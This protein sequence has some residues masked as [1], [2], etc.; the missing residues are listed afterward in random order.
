MDNLRTL[1]QADVADVEA[2]RSQ[3]TGSVVTPAD[4]DW[5]EARQA[6]NLAVDQ[7]P[8]LVAL[9][10]T[11]QDVAAVVGY[12]AENRLQVAPQGTGHNA[13]AL[14]SLDDTILLKTS[15]MRGV[16]IDAQARTARAEA[17]VIWIEVVEAAARHGLASLAGSSPDVG[18][19][20][21]TLG[22]GLSWLGRK[23]G[24]AANNVVA[25]EL[26]TADGRLVRATRDEEPDLFWAVRGGGGAFGVVTAIEF[27]LFPI[28]EVYAGVLWF[29]FERAADV[30]HAWRDFVAAGTPDELTTVGRLLQLPP[31][32]VIPE[33]VRGKSFVILEA[34]YL[35]DEAEGARLLEPL[36]ALGPVLDTVATIPVEALAHLHMDPEEPVPGAGDGDLLAELT[37]EAIDAVVAAAGP[38]SGS[39]LLS[40]ELRQLGGA[41]ARPAADHGAISA[42]DAQFALFAV[43]MAP[44]PE[45]KAK[46]EADSKAV[47]AAL[48][49]WVARQ[50][51]MN[52]V[53]RRE[54][55]R[56]FVSEAAYHRLRRI[57]SAVDP[58][59]VIRSNHPLEATA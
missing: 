30:L 19:V 3:L 35:G 16:T 13:I 29:P 46:A 50:T 7:R 36:R 8:A 43:G 58:Y 22:G 56:R 57:K 52:F 44:T 2:L 49:P 37:P 55:A 54:D 1:R 42:F 32:P 27:R 24:L 20:G 21:Y 38:G 5:D 4:E 11:A 33:P 34:I 6:W 18:V 51:Y 28:E 26:V 31:L 40:V 39:S 41:I 25:V 59:D 10:E 12:A 17:G 14:G 45:L 23:H 47:L 53:E 48:E 15:R 9:A